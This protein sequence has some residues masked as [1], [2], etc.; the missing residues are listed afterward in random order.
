MQKILKWFTPL[1]AVGVA[2]FI[3]FFLISI[4]SNETK[5]NLQPLE[6][7]SEVLIKE[8]KK[9]WLNHFSQTER[10]G[11]FYPVNEVF[12]KVDLNEKILSKTI[13]KLSASL[14]DPYQLFCLKEELGQ[15]KLKYYLSRDKNGVELLIYSQDIKKLNS[16]VKALKK[17]QISANV[18]L[19]KEDT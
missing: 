5:I 15:H 14:L 16:L 12:I 11:Y 9:T 13:Y 2:V 1:I 4:N 10:L 8:P 17:Y 18:G 6:H 3:I 7:K 19:H